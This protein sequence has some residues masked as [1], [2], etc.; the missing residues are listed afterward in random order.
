[1][2]A[3]AETT[4]QEGLYDDAWFRLR[5]LASLKR[6]NASSWDYSDSLLLYAPGG[7]DEYEASQQS[8]TAYAWL[9]TQPEQRYLQDVAGKM[10][11]ALPD[12]F[13]YVDLGPGTAHKEYYLFDA[14]QAAGKEFVYRP[15]DISPA[16]LEAA[17]SSAA[18]RGIAVQPI[19]SPFEDLATKLET[20]ERPRFVSLGLTYSNYPPETILSMLAAIA[21]PGGYAFVEVQL[22]ERVDMAAITNAYQRDIAT[23]SSLKLALLGIEHEGDVES[24]VCDDAVRMWAVLR[25]I[26]PQLE[27]VGVKR[28]DKLMTFMS[29]RPTLE[30]FE[31][32]IVKHFRSYELL[33]AEQP[34]VGALITPT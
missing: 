5:A 10:A 11:A 31:A 16:Y 25:N 1:M 13:E 7:D 18:G 20:G 8:D 4:F 27:A 33:D 9:I 6:I 32:D 3:A 12:Y 14:L 26:P 24:Y 29:L 22:R 21:G 34:F 23:L 28:G 2:A 19:L 17:A 30:Q 15:V